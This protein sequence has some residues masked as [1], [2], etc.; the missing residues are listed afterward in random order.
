MPAVLQSAVLTWEVLLPE[1]AL[2]HQVPTHLVEPKG[3]T[4]VLFNG[5]S[6]ICPFLYLKIQVL[7]VR[8]TLCQFCLKSFLRPQRSRWSIIQTSGAHQCEH[9]II[10]PS[11][12]WSADLT[13]KRS[14]FCML[15]IAKYFSNVGSITSHFFHLFL[16]PIL[17]F[18]LKHVLILPSPLSLSSFHN[19][20]SIWCKSFYHTNQFYS[21]WICLLLQCQGLNYIFTIKVI[22]FVQQYYITGVS[23]CSRCL[24]YCMQIKERPLNKNKY[25]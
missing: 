5:F 18:T 25:I 20:N 2:C 22:H 9:G 12:A 15:N 13:G 11:H 1:W 6:L 23:A 21:L 7:A 19:L 17:L 3:E 16:T 10:D 4:T 8:I 14:L 24:F